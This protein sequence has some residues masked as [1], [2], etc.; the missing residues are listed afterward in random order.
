MLTGAMASSLISAII[1]VKKTCFRLLL[2]HSVLSFGPY[3]ILSFLHRDNSPH[4]ICH[5]IP[6]LLDPEESRLCLFF[7]WTE[8]DGARCLAAV[9]CS[10]VTG[11]AMGHDELGLMKDEA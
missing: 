8:G 9:E 4:T 6:H 1:R 10:G 3:M 2:L 7:I 5:K 11:P